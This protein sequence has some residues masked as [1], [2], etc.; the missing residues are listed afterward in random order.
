MNGGLFI[1]FL[2]HYELF[3]NVF[4]EDELI[5]FLMIPAVKLLEFSMGGSFKFL[6]ANH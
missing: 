6:A 2:L 4:V 5:K 3:I 1:F